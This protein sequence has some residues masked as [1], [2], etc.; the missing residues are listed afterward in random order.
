MCEKFIISEATFLSFPVFVSK[1]WK[2]ISVGELQCSGQTL[3]A[4][5]LIIW[6][7][8]LHQTTYP[9]NLVEF[10]HYSIHTPG[11]VTPK[12]GQNNMYIISKTNI[13]VSRVGRKKDW[14]RGRQNWDEMNCIGW[15]TVREW[16]VDDMWFMYKFGVKGVVN[17]KGCQIHQISLNWSYTRKRFKTSFILNNTQLRLRQI[18]VLFDSDF[19]LLEKWKT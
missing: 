17:R 5:C 19:F 15:L 1:K 11:F 10:R 13:A 7:G 12:S 18:K 6:K 3:N 4:F 2:R 9:S 14:L 8:D 16:S